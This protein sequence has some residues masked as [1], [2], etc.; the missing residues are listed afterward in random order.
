MAHCIIRS[1]VAGVSKH[2]DS[3]VGVVAGEELKLVRERG[4]VFDA[5]AIKV[6]TKAGKVLG[7]VRRGLAFEIA[8]VIDC[9]VRVKCFVIKITG[10]GLLRSGVNVEL[11]IG[12]A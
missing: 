1:K 6:L 3:V 8:P 11:R 2:Q 7:Y 5:N 12:A 9:G 10:G 4:C